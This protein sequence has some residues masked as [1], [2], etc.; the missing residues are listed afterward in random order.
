MSGWC[1]FRTC[2]ELF[3]FGYLGI[4]GFIPLFGESLCILG[5]WGFVCRSDGVVESWV[6]AVVCEEGRGFG[7]WRDLVIGGELSEA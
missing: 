7:G 5:L 4:C 6:V 2:P 3:A 1:W